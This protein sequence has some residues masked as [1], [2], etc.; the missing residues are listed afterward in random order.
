MLCIH[1]V[2]KC[3]DR[4]WCFQHVG[5]IIGAHA[6]AVEV[7]KKLADGRTLAHLRAF[8]KACFAEAREKRGEIAMGEGGEFELSFIDVAQ[9]LLEIAPVCIGGVE[10]GATFGTEHFEESIEMAELSRFH[11][12]LRKFSDPSCSST[13]V[14][15]F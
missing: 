10:G 11:D 9:E 1:D 4:F 8:S 2:R 3:A 12:Y 14:A 5:R 15:V 7:A 13:L 6:F